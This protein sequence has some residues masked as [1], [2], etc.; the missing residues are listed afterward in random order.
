M[1]FVSGAVF[2]LTVGVFLLTV[3]LLG[4]LSVT[5]LIRNN[6]PL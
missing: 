3:E 4:L 5:V 2:L 6:V 1:P